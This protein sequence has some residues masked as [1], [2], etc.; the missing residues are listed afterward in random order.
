MFVEIFER[1]AL[2]LV[3]E[4]GRQD[5]QVL[6]WMCNCHCVD[7]LYSSGNHASQVRTAGYAMGIRSE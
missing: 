7:Y 4:D 2:C 6:L 3:L 5:V 1:C